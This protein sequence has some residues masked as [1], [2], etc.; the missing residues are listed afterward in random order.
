MLPGSSS[1]SHE[2]PI[3]RGLVEPTATRSPLLS[4]FNR[5]KL[6]CCPA[7]STHGQARRQRTHWRR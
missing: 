5:C 4:P 6:A 2:V 7:C 3:E 1:G